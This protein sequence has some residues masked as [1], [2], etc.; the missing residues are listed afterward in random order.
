MELSL[1]LAK[2]LGLYFLLVAILLAFRKEQFQGIVK[3][4]LESEGLIAFAGAL[5]L[6]FGLAILISHPIW[7][8]NWRGVI[9][10]LGVI[11]IFQGIFRLGF[12][13]YAQKM[14]STFPFHKYH[15]AL[16]LF[17]A[18]LGVYLTYFGFAHQLTGK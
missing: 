12:T 14:F 5:S 8:F 2:L 10:I 9:T 4:M 16:C 18:V 7:E 13:S 11:S 15:W 1:F 6:L 3:S 17:M